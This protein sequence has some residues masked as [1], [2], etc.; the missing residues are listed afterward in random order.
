MPQNYSGREFKATIAQADLSSVALGTA[1]HSGTAHEMRQTSVNDIA[2]D[3]GFQRTDYIRTGRRI[4]AQ[5]DHIAQYGSGTWTWGFDWLCEHEALM[6]VLLGNITQVA[7]TSTQAVVAGNLDATDLSHGVAT[8]DSCLNLVLHSPN[9]DEDRFMHSAIL[10][11]LTIS[12]DMNTNAGRP[13]MA[14][15]LMSGY[16]PTIGAEGTSPAT[17]TPDYSLGLFD[18]GTTTLGGDAIVVSAFSV[19]ISNPASRIGQRA[20]TGETDGY[21]RGGNFDLTGSVT[22]KLDNLAMNHINEYIT[23]A[24]NVPIVVEQGS[25]LS[26]NMPTCVITGYTPSY[27]DEGAMVEVTFRALANASDTLA[28]IK[29]T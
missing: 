6:Q 13:S 5:T 18:C 14:G 28:T 17:T 19:T 11:D 2:F 16:K 23:M 3:A 24:T 4:Q 21:V 9:T 1:N 12:M 10:Q 29:M 25:S 20:T 22:Y 7:D 15:T 27:A 26:F 8:G